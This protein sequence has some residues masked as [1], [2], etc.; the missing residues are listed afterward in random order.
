MLR[1]YWWR[2]RRTGELRSQWMH[3]SVVHS[4]RLPTLSERDLALLAEVAA[5]ELG[6]RRDNG[7]LMPPSSRSRL[8]PPSSTGPQTIQGESPQTLPLSRAAPSP[9]SRGAPPSGGPRAA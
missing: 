3:V 4:M 9:E 1:L 6:Y 7:V 8:G 5:S 2:D